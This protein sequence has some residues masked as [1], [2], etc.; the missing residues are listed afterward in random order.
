M[1]VVAER[2]FVVTV[3]LS[4]PHVGALDL[5]TARLEKQLPDAMAAALVGVRTVLSSEVARV[6]PYGMESFRRVRTLPERP[7]VPA[8]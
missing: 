5:M 1:T 8:A 4:V 7:Q 3:R 2:S 6:S